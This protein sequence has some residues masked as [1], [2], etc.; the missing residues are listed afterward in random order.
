MYGY[1]IILLFCV[2]EVGFMILPEN[3]RRWWR[4]QQLAQLHVQQVGSNQLTATAVSSTRR[5][6]L[7]HFAAKIF[8]NF[9]E[10]S[11]FNFTDDSFF[12]F[13]EKEGLFNFAEKRGTLQLH[14]KL[15]LQLRRN[16]F[17]ITGADFFGTDF[18]TQIYRLDLSKKRYYKSPWTQE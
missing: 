17:P 7:L 12:N 5:R 9:A 14:K 18:P 11:C 8:F 1:G 2:W 13:A 16:W 4:P 6:Q 10:D 3:L 15:I